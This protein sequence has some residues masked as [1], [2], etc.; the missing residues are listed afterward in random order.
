MT[1]LAKALTYTVL[2][3]FLIT[4][5]AQTINILDAESN[6]PISNVAVFNTKKTKSGVSNAKGEVSLSIFNT[7]ELINFKHIGY[8]TKTIAKSAIK[9]NTIYLISNTEG[10]DEII[11]SASNFKESKRDIARKIVSIKAKDI[12]F[13]NPQTSADL[14]QNS[15]QVFIQKSQLGG[16]SPIIRGFSTNRLLLTIDGVRMNNAIFRGGNLQNVISID[17]YS[18]Q[19]TEIILG[20]GAVIYGSDAIGGVMSFYTKKPKLSKTD[21]V[22]I[23]GNSALR[24]A[25]A[26]Q[27]KTTHIDVNIGLKKWAFISSFSYS[28]FGDLRMGK[29]GPNA[30]LRPEFVITTNAED[31]V[32]KN[33]NP[34]LQ[35]FTAYNQIN[36]MQKVLFSP[37]NNLNLNLGVFYTATSNV[38]RYDRLIEY[39]N[40]TLKSAEWYYGP[41]HW[42]M[43][44]LQ[45]NHK[46]NNGI[47]DQLKV[48]TAYQYFEESRNDRKFNA[49]NL[50]SRKEGVNA[51]SFN[52]DFEKN[53]SSKAFLFYGTEYIFNQVTSVGNSTSITNNNS[54]KVVSRYPNNATWQS[55]AAYTNLKYRS[56][57]KFIINAGARY[58][59]INS[60]ANFSENNRFLNLP[61]N[62]SS[63]TS[64]ALTGAIGTSWLPSKIIDFKCNISSAFR[65]PNIDDIGKVFDSQP[66]TVVIPNNNLKPEY[67]YG[68]EFAI[69]LNAKNA[70]RVETSAYYTYLDNALI[71]RNTTLNGKT[72]IIYDGEPSQIQ[73]IQNASIS[74]IYGFELGV[75]AP[76]TKTLKLTSQYS[77]VDGKDE[78]DGKKTNVRHV[79]PGFGNT[80]L[81]WDNKK[82]K[83]DGYFEFNSMLANKRLSP[84]EIGKA[85]LYAKDKNGNP[86]S[87]SW[88]TLNLTAHY[89]IKE[90][91]S[92]TASLENITDRRYRTYSSGIAAP[93]RNLI[94]ALNL[95]F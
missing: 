18:I 56:N 25:T 49:E 6:Y 11:L 48:T 86:Y 16:G 73:S 30:Y 31:K 33:N 87:P 64:N 21:S 92:I 5:K 2:F 69:G 59:I 78:A 71:R 15:G 67:A 35:K 61:F 27:E 58:T 81:I 74:R 66:G 32:V 34:L 68:G 95:G 37:K 89:S 50:R 24:Y 43:T 76:L 40:E 29:Y 19:N 10:L 88:H 17:P 46:K 26:N 51:F 1:F 7:A 65:A 94:V 90:N 38:P 8:Q 57:N 52:T 13:N 83:I 44:N 70:I 80:H 53:I 36:A 82:F 45:A 42:F 93:G 54:K 9:N 4:S 77:F 23:E 63:N 28:N 39:K 72:T 62:T 60:E 14:L 3:F 20:T 55:G 12:A 84:S 79:A 91:S 75:N 22:Y 85:Y 41:Q 47:Y